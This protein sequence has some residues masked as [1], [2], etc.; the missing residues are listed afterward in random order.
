[1]LHEYLL[2]HKLDNHF[3]DIGGEI[4]ING[5]NNDNPWLVGIQNPLS[6]QNNASIVIEKN[7]IFLAIATSG[8]YRNF[9]ADADGNKISHTINP[10]SLESIKHNVLSA[11]VVHEIS[12]TYADAYATAF[13]AMGA[14]LAIETANKNNIALMLIVQNDNNLDII[15]SKKWYDLVI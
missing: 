15:Y 7:N 2:Q 6:L 8:E 3:I 9:K 4:I 5:N 10:N 13:N 11:T 12:A 14:D 1:M